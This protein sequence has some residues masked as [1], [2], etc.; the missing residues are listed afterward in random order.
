[1]VRQ[2]KMTQREAEKMVKDRYGD[3]AVLV[4]VQAANPAIRF[5]IG[6]YDGVACPETFRVA[7]LG[8]CWEAAFESAR[9]NPDADHKRSEIRDCRERLERGMN[10]GQYR[11]EKAR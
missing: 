9:I 5:R 7:G 8:N 3:D 2:N 10:G 1:M 11:T 4:R 6:Y